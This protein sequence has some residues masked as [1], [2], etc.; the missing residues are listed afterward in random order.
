[1]ARDY[2]TRDILYLPEP[3]APTRLAK[4]IA[5]LM[6]AALTIGVD[7]TEAWRLARKVGWDPVPAVRVR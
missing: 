1:V 3:E 4:Q 6:A 5:Q 7:E 2:Q